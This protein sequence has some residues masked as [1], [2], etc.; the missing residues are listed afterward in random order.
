MLILMLVLSIAEHVVRREM[1]KESAMILGPGD[2]KLT[3]PSLMAIFRMFFSV[4][5]AAIRMDGK[6]HR[7]FNEP[8]R[9]NVKAVMRY[10]SIPEDIFIRG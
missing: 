10:L 8:L 7:G 1:T 2:K 4:K 6:L 5:T 3:R 9:P